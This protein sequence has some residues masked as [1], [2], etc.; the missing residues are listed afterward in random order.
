MK[1]GFTLIE[2]LAV[3]V[4][5]GLISVLTVPAIINQLAKAKNQSNDV[6]SEIIRSAVDLYLDNHQDEYSK[7]SGDSYCIQLKTLVDEGFLAEP[8]IDPLTD[9]SYSVSLYVVVDVSEGE[10][11]EYNLSE[12]CSEKK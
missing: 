5:L 8:I 10:V 3:I 7:N 1:K 12:V 9:K 11:L 6:M 4:V 2:L